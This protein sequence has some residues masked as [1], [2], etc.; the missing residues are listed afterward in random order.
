MAYG[1]IEYDNEGKPICEICKKSFNRVLSH[2]RQ[3]HDMSEREY[4]ITFGFDLGKGIC[5]KESSERSRE[6]TLANYDKCIGKNLIHC[7]KKS[8]Y[9][10]GHLGRT[11]DMVQEQTRLMLK[12]RLE[13]PHMVE[14][15]RKSGERVGNSGLGNIKR[16]QINK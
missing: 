14:A 6:T 13:E 2:V 5:S 11:K 8:R 10:K 16:W 1:V 4:K 9:C 12:K 3:K 7:G 15:M